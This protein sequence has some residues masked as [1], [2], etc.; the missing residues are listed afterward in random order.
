M[1]MYISMYICTIS[2]KSMVGG[3]GEELAREGRNLRGNYV[4]GK[5]EERE[6]GQSEQPR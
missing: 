2:F 1:Y 6:E 4:D 5:K 3:W